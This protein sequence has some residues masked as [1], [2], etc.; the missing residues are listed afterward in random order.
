[1][2][3][4]EPDREAALVFMLGVREAELER[5]RAEGWGL[6]AC[7]TRLEEQVASLQCETAQMND[8]RRRWR[9]ISWDTADEVRGLYVRCHELGAEGWAMVALASQDLVAAA[10][11]LLAACEAGRAYVDVL[12][13]AW[14]A[15]GGAKLPRERGGGAI[16]QSTKEDLDVAMNRWF[17]LNEAALAKA[18]GQS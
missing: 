13:D 14:R 10:P 6:V 4:N 17:E 3:P 5:A 11:D 1:M 16:V 7:V 18:R 12:H 9:Q 15:G 8:Q 2:T